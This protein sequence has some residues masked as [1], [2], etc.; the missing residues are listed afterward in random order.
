[1]VFAKKTSTF[2]EALCEKHHIDFDWLSEEI[3][4][5]YHAAKVDKIEMLDFDYRPLCN[6]I[7]V[8]RNKGLF[9]IPATQ[10]INQ[11]DQFKSKHFD[12]YANA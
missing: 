6:L 3:L 4:R 10:N 1:M 12:F 9:I 5:Q 7:A 8:G 11:L 2:I